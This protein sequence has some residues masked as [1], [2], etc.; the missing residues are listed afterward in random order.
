MPVMLSFQSIFMF[1][2]WVYHRFF[3]ANS[4]FKAD[5]V[6]QRHT[7]DLWLSEGA[8]MISRWDEYEQFLKVAV[9]RSTVS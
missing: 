6:Q 8:G 2:R 1:N 4:N 3:V 7:S 5:H 9:E